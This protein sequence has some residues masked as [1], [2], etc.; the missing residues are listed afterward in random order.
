[1]EQ[2]DKPKYLVI[3]SG[4][5]IAGARLEHITENVSYIVKVDGQAIA[6]H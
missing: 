4:A 3:D 5:I 2:T 6:N 1:M